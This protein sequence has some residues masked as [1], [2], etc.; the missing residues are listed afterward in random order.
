[1]LP[2]RFHW[3]GSVTWSHPA[4][5]VAGKCLLA[6]DAGGKGNR[7]GERRPVSAIAFSAGHQTP[8]SLF[9]DI[10]T[11]PSPEEMPEVPRSRCVWIT[12]Q[13]LWRMHCLLRIE[14]RVL[15]CVTC[16]LKKKNTC[17][18]P[19]SLSFQWWGRDSIKAPKTPGWNRVNI[20]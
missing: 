17:L 19:A 9:P 5:R 4:A 8:V 11:H 7:F 6:A 18:L 14:M 13:D 12:F 1:M 20:K 10:S 3:P 2:P 16:E 15:V